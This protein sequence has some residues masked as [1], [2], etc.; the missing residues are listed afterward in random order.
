MRIMK[1]SQLF[2]TLFLVGIS[3][4]ILGGNFLFDSKQHSSFDVEIYSKNYSLYFENLDESEGVEIEEISSKHF[5]FDKEFSDSSITLSSD[6][7]YVDV[8]DFTSARVTLK[9]SSNSTVTDVY[10]C[11]ELDQT[12]CISGWELQKDLE[13]F[14]NETHYWFYVIEFSA[15]VGSGPP[16]GGHINFIEPDSDPE[17]SQFPFFTFNMSYNGSENISLTLDFN[18]SILSYFNFENISGATIV[19]DSQYELNGTLTSISTGTGNGTRGTYGIIDNTADVL[20][21][22]ALNESTY[23]D[24]T[25]SFRFYS[26][27]LIDSSNE[28]YMVF[29]TANNVNIFLQA[30]T[31]GAIRY[32]NG[33]F[34]FDTLQSSWAADTWYHVTYTYNG[35]TNDLRVYVDGVLDTNTTQSGQSL[36]TGTTHQAFYYGG[37]GPSYSGNV[38][39]LFISNRALD[40]LEVQALYNGTSQNLIA[41]VEGLA[42]GQYPYRGCGI[43][44]G[45]NYNCTA[46]RIFDVYDGPTPVNLYFNRTSTNNLTEPVYVESEFT[47]NM[48]FSCNNV[49]WS[50]TYAFATYQINST[51]ARFPFPVTNTSL[52]CNATEGIKTTFVNVSGIFQ[53]G[54]ANTSIIYDLT[55]PTISNVTP[56]NGTVIISSISNFSFI[57]NDVA[58]GIDYCIL[59]IDNIQNGGFFQDPAENTLVSIL[60][61]STDIGTGPHNYSISCFDIAGNAVTSNQTAIDVAVTPPSIS[62]VTVGGDTVFGFGDDIVISATIPPPFGGLDTVYFNITYVN[63]TTMT[64]TPINVTSSLFRYTVNETF[65]EGNITVV[66]F[67]NATNG[68]SDIEQLN[69]SIDSQMSV[70]LVTSRDTYI[71]GEFVDLM[72]FYPWFDN[73]WNYRVM[74]T[75]TPDSYTGYVF[76][77]RLNFTQILAQQDVVGNVDVGSFR[78]IQY[79]PSGNPIF[80]DSSRVGDER[81]FVNATITGD[82]ATDYDSLTNAI[83]EVSFVS[84][85]QLTS[86]DQRYFAIYFDTIQ[87][88]AKTA[89][90]SS[91]AL[92]YPVSCTS[93][94]VQTVDNTG[95]H[96]ITPIND[97]GTFGSTQTLFTQG[98][99]VRGAAVGDYDGDGDCDYVYYSNSANRFYGVRQNGSYTFTSFFDLNI[100]PPGMS[101]WNMDM[102]PGDYDNDGDIDVVYSGNNDDI[103]ILTY[104]GGNFDFTTS[105]ITTNSPG[106]AGRCKDA[107]D[108]NG[109]GNLDFIYSYNGAG[110]MYLYPGDGDNTFSSPIFLFDTPGSSNDPYGCT[111]ADFDNDGD[112]D[113]ATLGGAGGD[114][115]LFTNDG[116][117]TSYTDQGLI[118]DLANHGAL[119]NYDVNQDGY[120]DI[121]ASRWSS[122]RVRYY[123]NDQDS[124]FSLITDVS[125]EYTLGLGAPETSFLGNNFSIGV[126][127]VYSNKTS[128]S[129]VLNLPNR[130]ENF[131]S[132]LEVEFFNSSGPGWQFSQLI[133]DESA[134]PE[135]SLARNNSFNIREKHLSTNQFNSTTTFGEYRFKKYF[136]APNGTTLVDNGSIMEFYSNNFSITA[137]TIAPTFD[138][139][140]YNPTSSGYGETIEFD[141]YVSDSGTVDTVLVN[142]TSPNA[143]VQTI[144]LVSGGSTLYTGTYTNTWRNGTYNLVFFTNDS[145]GNSRINSTNS[146]DIA[147]DLTTTLATT[148]DDYFV[149]EIVDLTSAFSWAD[150]DWNYRKQITLD[151]KPNRRY[152]AFI[153]EQINFSQEL[154]SLGLSGTLSNTSIRVVEYDSLGDPIVY[155]ASASGIDQYAIPFTYEEDLTFSPITNAIVTVGFIVNGST[156]ASTQRFFQLYFDIEENGIK[157]QNVGFNNLGVTTNFH[158]DGDTDME[159][160]LGHE[161][162]NMIIY[163]PVNDSVEFESSDHGD[164]AQ[165][166]YGDMDRN[167][168]T[169]ILFGERYNNIWA[170]EYTGNVIG[171]T[172]TFGYVHY[173]ISVGDTD[174]DG[175]QEMVSGYYSNSQLYIYGYD[176]SSYVTEDTIFTS[177]LDT[178]LMNVAVGDFNQDGEDEIAVVGYTNG[179]WFGVYK[180]NTTSGDYDNIYYLPLT[181]TNG[182]LGFYDSDND[183]MPNI[184]FGGEGGEIY[185]VEYDEVTDDFALEW[186][187]DMG[188]SWV[189]SFDF[190]DHDNDGFTDVLT[191]RNFGRQVI[192]F[193]FDGTDDYIETFRSNTAST[194]RGFVPMYV[195]YDNDGD[196]EIAVGGDSATVK[197][198]EIGTVTPVF[199]RQFNPPGTNRISSFY[200]DSMLV[201]GRGDPRGIQKPYDSDSTLGSAEERSDSTVKSLVRNIGGTPTTTYTYLAVDFNN[202]TSGNWETQQVIVN[203]VGNATPNSEIGIGGLFNL[204]DE[205]IS[206]GSFN[207]TGYDPGEYRINFS[208]RTPNGGILTNNDSTLIEA[209]YVFNL[210]LDTFGPNILGYSVS[211][212]TTGFGDFI[213]I[214]VDAQDFSG[215]DS[216]WT[217]ITYP[218]GTTQSITIPSVTS[219]RYQF[220]F[221]NTWQR[222]NYTVEI[223]VNDTNGFINSTPSTQLNID[224]ELNISIATLQDTYFANQFVDLTSPFSWWNISWNYRVPINLDATSTIRPYV[225]VKERINFTNELN[226]LSDVGIFDNNSLRL[227]EYDAEGNAVVYNAS[228]SGDDR[229]IIPLKMKTFSDFSTTTNAYGT[230]EFKIASQTAANTERFFML[231]FDIEEN[232]IKSSAYKAYEDPTE[233]IAYARDNGIVIVAEYTGTGA[234]GFGTPTT[235]GDFSNQNDLTRGIGV[236]D[237]DNDGDFDI[238]HGGNSGGT[239][240]DLKIFEQTSPMNF[241]S[242]GIVSGSSFYG[243]S[244]AMDMAIGDFNGDGNHDVVISGNTY[245]TYIYYG[246]GDLTFGNPQLIFDTQGNNRG[247]DAGDFNNDGDLDFAM[248]MS[249]F[250][251]DIF[252]FTGLGDGTF[253]EFFLFDPPSNDGYCIAAGDFNGDDLEDL[254]YGTRSGSADGYLYIGDGNNGFDSGTVVFD[255]NNYFACDA[256]DFDDNTYLDLYLTKFTSDIVVEHTGFGDG[257]FDSLAAATTIDTPDTSLAIA[258]PDLFRYT[259]SQ[260]NA[261]TRADS[262]ISSRA[263]NQLNRT[264]RPYLNMTIEFFNTTSMNWTFVDGIINSSQEAIFPLSL[265]NLKTLYDA[266]GR[267]NTTTLS[268]GTYSV[269]IQL[270]DDQGNVLNDSSGL[271]QARANF[272]ITSDFDGPTYNNFFVQPS[273]GGYKQNITIQ[274][275]VLDETAVDRVFANITFPDNSTLIRNLTQVFGAR[276]TTYFNDTWEYGNYNITIFANDT[277]GQQTNISQNV[278]VS[279]ASTF[280]LNTD[281]L[282]YYSNRTVALENSFL[283]NSDW[284]NY[285]FFLEM[286]IEKFNDSSMAWE[287]YDIVVNETTVRNVT[288]NQSLNLTPIW[289]GAGLWNT[290]TSPGGFYRVYTLL[291]NNESVTLQQNDSTDLKGVSLAFTVLNVTGVPLINA[292][293]VS[294]AITGVGSTVSFNANIT[295]DVAVTAAWINITFPNATVEQ[296]FMTNV[297]QDIFILNFTKTWQTGQYNVT[298][299]AN[300]SAANLASLD[301]SFNISSQVQMNVRTVENIYFANNTVL[302]NRT[303]MW[304]DVDWKYRQPFSVTEN[305]EYDLT[306]YSLYVDFDSQSLISSNKLNANGSDIR[307]VD[308][309]MNEL[310][311]QVENATLNTNATRVWFE[312]N[313]TNSSTE[314]FHIYYGN[315]EAQYPSYPSRVTSVTGTVDFTVTM[316]DGWVYTTNDA[317]GRVSD[318]DFSGSDVCVDGY[319]RNTDSY[320]GSWWNDRNFDASIRANGPLFVEVYYNDSGYGSYNS[321]GSILRLFDDGLY[322]GSVFMNFSAGAT[323]DL[324]Y[325]RLYTDTSPDDKVVAW[326]DNGNN[327]QT[328][329]VTTGNIFDFD[330]G[331]DWI[332]QYWSNYGGA[333]SSNYGGTVVTQGDSFERANSQPTSNNQQHYS[334]SATFAI[335]DYRQIDYTAYTGVEGGLT[336][337]RIQ[338]KQLGVPPTLSLSSEESVVSIVTDSNYSAIRNSLVYPMNVELFTRVERFTGSWTP[339]QTIIDNSTPIFGT[340]FRDIANIWERE[341]NFSVGSNPVGQYR[342]YVELR[343]NQTNILQ[344]NDGS[345]MNATY[346]FNVSLDTFGPS[347]VLDQLDSSINGY[348]QNQSFTANISD[349][350]TVAN[351]WIEVTAPNSSLINFTLSNQSVVIDGIRNRYVFNGIS[352]TTWQRGVYNYTIFARDSL[353][354]KGQSVQYNFTIQSSSFINVSVSQTEYAANVNVTLTDST[355]HN[356]GSLRYT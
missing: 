99:N 32:N 28:P 146:F 202:L 190:A 339:I 244:F 228:R 178:N 312:M 193:E 327:L 296:F 113:I 264:T 81:Y 4:V 104:G 107:G 353:G 332:G 301:S 169:E 272:T 112:L 180:Y 243:N 335:N 185:N 263:L 94:F 295:D 49:S 268:S 21:L 55:N 233:F 20:T 279:A 144:P 7:L 9:K 117:G 170:F 266:A 64:R 256:Y 223:F 124:T 292:F 135:V 66:I 355:I 97:D 177:T 280:T 183:G 168:K 139:I 83:L 310:T 25:V 343:D 235:L 85:E 110:N 29:Y 188:G 356:V 12:D 194:I 229:Y 101:G 282:S 184:W 165:F 259:V 62:N 265:L 309:N 303:N 134:G 52:G 118:F 125:S 120:Q 224:T 323:E 114:V 337:L 311:I 84:S 136:Y 30:S 340:S 96:T 278:E 137:D 350:S 245:D 232:G 128:Y 333:C 239:Y 72:S 53:P 192:I 160:I 322:R 342:V 214:Q 18:R 100:T 156:P 181:T 56:V 61:N 127:E 328:S 40:P 82:S 191:S 157:T 109:D 5:L 71:E 151:S 46:L 69:L 217:N 285:S 119:D 287:F 222:G 132:R 313:I 209:N 41:F 141:V 74:T 213:T 330:L 33:A 241:V 26:N 80:F 47:V 103:H 271:L 95:I 210:S 34:N 123:Q 216:A 147:V 341:G 155:N 11:A 79:D 187:I 219:L 225:L 305:S 207:S 249:G 162:G 142:V 321:Y 8:Q 65:R 1:F 326:V 354:N 318:M 154:A 247:K 302:L 344:N 45:G 164:M 138:L 290:T 186:S 258:T 200:G 315:S 347:I 163:N 253:N 148:K 221:N 129:N 294:P 106:G 16:N 58:D 90:N 35:S 289:A 133:Y 93:P 44:Q 6:V 87:N 42:N 206:G 68:L 317:Y 91:A 2:L 10:R 261:Q 351:A 167:G 324:Y 226:F 273:P 140:L 320:P 24:F 291:K 88:G 57:V 267:F 346:Y 204:R 236:A 153:E 13:I 78:V 325:Y 248:T 76:K 70:N 37:F 211:P 201:L 251:G 299:Y 98:T 130:E 161:N 67:A 254:F 352:N 27:N 338:G 43:D 331:E 115:H 3:L 276:Y 198:Y 63:G 227:V 172:A 60:R 175:E 348:G 38:D 286:G 293:S 260:F 212:N 171:Q 319:F 174:Y 297:S 176:G 284:T 19:D 89:Y 314:T 334:E 23:T 199:T 218:N 288:L 166:A 39:E 105:S 102:A 108:M 215:V 152:D 150:N 274:I 281:R 257:T 234:T 17:I 54:Y 237:F 205:F 304:W 197:I 300:D 73:S 14:Q 240:I 283:N 145:S 122:A 269:F 336:N 189:G 182:G 252:M 277:F 75:L 307:I 86:V 316:N 329:T 149:C 242:A 262:S 208:F 345:F 255:V 158:L 92:K 116:N 270:E 246:N 173:A 306:N 126:L 59:F 250:G 238:I 111:V 220:D 121:I 308:N 15:Y 36:Q 196:L 195:D 48:S 131:F 179:D 143:T 298:L 51:T 349:V 77:E 203:D 230:V 231:Y 22:Q 159:L 275:D 50:P 31:A